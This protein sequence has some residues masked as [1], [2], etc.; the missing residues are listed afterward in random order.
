MKY[1]SIIIALALILSVNAAEAQL[2]K[3]VV[4]VTGS[5]IN[6]QTKTPES[7]DITVTDDTGKIINKVTSNASE[8]GYYYVTALKPGNVYY[9]NIDNEKFFNEKFEVI[10]PNSDKYVEISRDFLL[11]PLSKSVKLEFPVP[12]FELNKSKLRF[13]SSI[14]LESITNSL[15]NNPNV[16][17]EIVSYPD[18][19][20]NPKENTKLTEER[21]HSLKDYFVVQG[22]NPSRISI[23]SNKKADPNHP[24]PEEKRAKGKRYIGSTY[25]V[26]K[27]F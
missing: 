16:K 4:A 2:I 13:G 14:I 5:I 1:S 18:D 11:K 26:V 24:L 10:I 9:F 7:V 8:G 12:P 25:I 27:D 3:T 22:I 19:N 20:A 15:I 23:V 6:Y 17:F 21:A